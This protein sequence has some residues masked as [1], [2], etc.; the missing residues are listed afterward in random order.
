[1]DEKKCILQFCVFKQL[2]GDC[3]IIKLENIKV[4]K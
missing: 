4:S 3:M 2:I 1:M